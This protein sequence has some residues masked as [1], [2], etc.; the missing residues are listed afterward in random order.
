MTASFRS[1]A[2]RILQAI[3]I[4]GMFV[5]AAAAYPRLPDRIPL[6]WGIDGQPNGWTDKTFGLW[7]LPVMTL[8]LAVL[9]ALLQS[10]DPKKQN[11][12]SFRRPWEILQ[13]ALTCFFTYVFALQLWASLA[14]PAGTAMVRAIIAGVGVLF[15]VLGNFMGKI[16]QNFFIGLRTPWS[17]SDPEVWQK[18]QRIGG[19]SFVAGGVLLLLGAASG[20]V[21]PS[22]LIGIIVLV[23]LVPVVASYVFYRRK[24]GSR[25]GSRA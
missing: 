4:V 2:V 17:L 20:V 12:A 7:L 16:R 24:F 19:R 9:F 1:S 15:L 18:S 13:L 22:L 21:Y 23:A 3:L 6:H 5:A 10:I 11:Y 8:G 14:A 25:T